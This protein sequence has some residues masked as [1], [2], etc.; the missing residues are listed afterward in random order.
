MNTATLLSEYALP[1]TQQQKYPAFQADDYQPKSLKSKINIC[2]AESSVELLSPE[3]IEQLNLEIKPVT[4]GENEA[5]VFVP[6]STVEFVF[7]GLPRL[8]LYDKE[9]QRYEAL[10][11]GTK[12]A[13]T[14]K[15]TAAKLFM[16]VA[17][18]GELL[19]DND[20]QPQVFTLNL[21]SSKTSLLKAKFPSAGDGTLHSLNAALTKHYHLKGWITHL[22]S[23]KLHAMPE[24]FTSS[25][26]GDSSLGI[27]FALDGTATPLSEPNQKAMFELLQHPDLLA[28]LQNPYKLASLPPTNASSTFTQPVYG[29]DLDIAY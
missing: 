28:D 10:T 26:S 2:L 23:V 13:G 12:L 19:L 25:V 21:K 24:K 3:S 29:E 8:F 17:I 16:C 9:T 5:N 7:L 1:D 14:K 6:R 22:A 11:S 20:A 4:F 15:V 18:A 27:K